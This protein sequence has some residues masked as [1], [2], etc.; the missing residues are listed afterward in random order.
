MDRKVGLSDLTGIMTSSVVISGTI[1]MLLAELEIYSWFRWAALV[2]SVSV[3]L[4]TR[5]GSW[6]RFPR[7]R[8][9]SL[10]DSILF[11]LA[12][13][14][15][16]WELLRPFE[17]VIGGEDTGVYFN[18]AVQIALRGSVLVHDPVMASLNQT[19]F[20]SLYYPTFG[21]WGFY[22]CQHMGFYIDDP[23]KG[24]VVPQFFYLLPSLMAAFY[25]VDGP[26]TMLYFTPILSLLSIM[27]IY[28]I[29][30]RINGSLVA[31]LSTTLLSLNFAQIYFSRAPFSDDLLQLL[32]LVAILAYSK[33]WG[34]EHFRFY[35]SVFGLTVGGLIITKLEGWMGALVLLLVVTFTF[36]HQVLSQRFRLLLILVTCYGILSAL[37]TWFFWR[38]YVHDVALMLVSRIG[39]GKLAQFDFI[40]VGLALAIPMT[41]LAGLSIPSL[42]SR[43]AQHLPKLVS[44]NPFRTSVTRLR[45]IVL[46]LLMTAVF[47]GYFVWPSGG[48]TEGS[49]NLVKLGWYVGG[50]PGLAAGLI[51]L[52]I[53]ASKDWKRNKALVSLFV[54]YF[55][56]YML[57]GIYV[58]NVLSPVLFSAR[59]PWWARRF[60]AIV[61]PTIA[62]GIGELV[63]DISHLRVRK[64]KV[65]LPVA[66]VVCLVILVLTAQHL[67]LIQGYIE[68]KQVT[69]EIQFV[70]SQF[71]SDSM[72][73]YHDGGYGEWIAV[74]LRFMY[75]MNPI[76]FR[77]VNDEVTRV[78]DLW[79]S[80]GKHVFLIQVPGDPLNYASELACAFTIR[81]V[82]N[83]DIKFT[84][85]S[86]PVGY[87]PTGVTIGHIVY[88]ICEL[89]PSPSRSCTPM[90]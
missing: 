47:Y 89:S 21:G 7:V 6:R 82:A 74:P 66:L 28:V 68:Y 63:R 56:F 19:T 86:G 23:S 29:V 79:L 8:R 3:L 57:G 84:T 53:I 70:A 50:F 37:S 59:H 90:T 43:I 17:D 46:V 69:Q 16:A 76:P 44:G 20:S 54:V 24:L 83:I 35:A 15:A 45:A 75:G 42:L 1:A 34:G 25:S 10:R 13:V 52:A 22:G 33:M 5:N 30:R 67:P 64:F 62:I 11:C 18:T 39:L 48:I 4:L 26:T 12:I 72:I 80:R 36:R 32:F 61:I 41:L 40:S 73:L 65:G 9:P 81:G 27:A 55:V 58:D 88:V 2:I 31:A 85:I 38:I 87:F 78:I 71:P 51:G 60:V 14:I 77:E 49:W